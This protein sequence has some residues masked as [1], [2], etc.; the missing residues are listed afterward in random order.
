MYTSAAMIS[1]PAGLEPARNAVTL[2]Q[3]TRKP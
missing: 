2:L 3:A 1:A